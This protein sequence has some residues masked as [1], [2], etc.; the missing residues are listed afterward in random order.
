M[1]FLFCVRITDEYLFSFELSFFNSG[2]T[3]FDK[4]WLVS[5]SLFLIYL[6][7]VYSLSFSVWHSQCCLMIVEIEVFNVWFIL[8]SFFI[9]WRQSWYLSGRTELIL[10]ISKNLIFLTGRTIYF[11]Y[12]W[13]F[14]ESFVDFDSSC[15]V[16]DGGLKSFWICL[17]SSTSFSFIYPY[18][19]LL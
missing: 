4:F 14:L 6:Y 18:S 3:E 12:L 17:A 16:S 10:L 11:I 9:G 7:L 8:L 19:G 2:R 15:I 13:P 1:L 5:I